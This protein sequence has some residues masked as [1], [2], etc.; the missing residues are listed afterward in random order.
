MK[1]VEGSIFHLHPL[2]RCNLQCLHCYSGSSPRG[3]RT[4]PLAQALHAVDLAARWGY[5]TL[6]IS[7]GEPLLYSGLEALLDGAQKAGMRTSLITN[8]LLCR[9]RADVARLRH[10]QT[11][12]VSIDGPARVHDA[13][14]AREGAFAGAARTVQRLA[15]A[16]LSPW[17][18]CGVTAHNVATVEEVVAHARSWG[19]RGIHFHLVEPAGRAQS[20]TPETFL[21]P[22]ARL[23]LYV[24]TA[25][26]AVAS[27]PDIA[28]HVD[29]LH[30]DTILRHPALL[31]AADNH[32]ASMPPAQSIKVLVMQADGS[33]LPLCHGMH[34]RYGVGNLE[35]G[36]DGEAMW[37]R[38]FEQTYPALHRLACK[39]LANLRQDA[40]IEVINPGDWLAERSHA[41]L[42]LVA[43]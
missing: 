8:G 3:E 15:D 25:L 40:R 19:A 34:A 24:D 6:A 13:M 23:R 22:A 4:L 28:V 7:G 1:P 11:V 18:S 20:L 14:R 2:E 37:R 38:F 29:L 16:G 30:R 27:H 36:G 5:R 39:A 31:Y 33:V 32:T 43:L 10:A 26:L 21:G 41:Q 17:V 12:S 9:T 35:E 42:S